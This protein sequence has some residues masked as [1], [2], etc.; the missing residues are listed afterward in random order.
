M[1][2]RL[3]GLPVVLIP[4]AKERADKYGGKAADYTRLFPTHSEC[5][6]KKREADTAALMKR[7]NGQ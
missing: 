6:L 5:A 2:C 4:S 1:N 7:N 3:C